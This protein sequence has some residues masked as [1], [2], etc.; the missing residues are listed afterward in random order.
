M[1]AA[2][3]GEARHA[4][5][6]PRDRPPRQ[7]SLLRKRRQEKPTRRPDRDAHH[8]R[9]DADQHRADQQAWRDPAVRAGHDQQRRDGRERQAVARASD[10]AVQ[11]RGP[12]A[13]PLAAEEDLEVV[14]THEPVHRVHREPQSR[15]AGDRQADKRGEVGEDP[16]EASVPDDRG[17]GAAR[18]VAA[19][20]AR[21]E[22][23]ATFGRNVLHTSRGASPA[24]TC[25]CAERRR[26]GLR[27]LVGV[28]GA[29]P[30]RRRG[31]GVGG[32]QVRSWRWRRCGRPPPRSWWRS[33]G[34]SRRARRPPCRRGPRR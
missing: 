14:G 21:V 1:A 23:A 20:L 3:E 16:H 29:N 17:G 18:Q 28:G 22:G 15:G 8:R 9:G 7:V 2:D 31:F 34:R 10:D 5:R 24:A 13:R 26:R 25:H 33:R 12:E 27:R 11:Q 6:P 30:R 32:R 4:R 19:V